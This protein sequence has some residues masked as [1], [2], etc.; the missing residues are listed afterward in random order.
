MI[1]KKTVYVNSDSLITT[2]ATATTINQLVFKRG[3][4]VTLNVIFLDEAQAPVALADG[5]VITMAVKP[6]GQYD[7][8]V[9]YAYSTVTV[10]GQSASTGY[11][12]TLNLNNTTLAEE[13]Q[14][15]DTFTEDI[16][17]ITGM[18]ELSWTNGGNI[19]QSTQNTAEVLINNDVIRGD[20]AT[21]LSLPSPET[22]LTG[23]TVRFDTSQSLTD[24]QKAR[25]QANIGLPKTNWSATSAPTVTDASSE[26]YGIGSLWI[27]T[28]NK[29][30]YLRLA[31]TSS[32]TDWS[33]ITL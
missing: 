31:N 15:D 7:S 29:E 23:R 11:S 22:W 18:L 9:L 28:A 3:D 26:G 16:L 14:L 20:E 4:T 13:F 2:S 5:Y 19:F 10:A 21:P 8:D 1:L 32:S 12:F 6:T 24:I 33:K 30:A 27:D 25:V 17:N